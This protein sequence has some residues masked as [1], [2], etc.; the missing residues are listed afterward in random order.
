MLMYICPNLHSQNILRTHK[1]I[2]WMKIVVIF[3]LNFEIT[4]ESF[5]KPNLMEIIYQR[6]KIETKNESYQVLVCWKVFDLTVQ[7]ASQH[8][9]SQCCHLDSGNVIW[10]IKFLIHKT[11]VGLGTLF[12]GEE[13]FNQNVVRVSPF[14]GH[15]QRGHVIAKC[16][17]LCCEQIVARKCK[18]YW[19]LIVKLTRQV[20]TIA[21]LCNVLFCFHTDDFY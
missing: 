12:S 19:L 13:F 14:D 21:W 2:Q 6:N 8:D 16:M 5:G 10:L 1:M 17:V 18:L 15:H 7:I 11:W 9:I 3:F 20:W 4:K